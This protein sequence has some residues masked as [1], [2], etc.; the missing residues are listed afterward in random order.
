MVIDTPTTT[1]D[2]SQQPTDSGDSDDDTPPVSHRPTHKPSTP[3]AKPIKP[4]PIPE[5]EDKP[6][7]SCGGAT[8]D[9]SK[10]VVLLGYGDGLQ[11][12]QDPLTRA[13]LATIIY[14][15]LDENSIAGFD[16]SE[17]VF[18]DVSPDSWCYQPIQIIQKVGIVTGTGGGCYSPMDL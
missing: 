15:L 17:Q 9:T 14:R 12:E 13:Q 7:L 4:T 5:S 8:L 3:I 18:I 2:T 16:I 6:K 1:P 11:H 10:T